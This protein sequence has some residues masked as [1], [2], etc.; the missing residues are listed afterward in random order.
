MLR[1]VSIMAEQDDLRAFLE[2]EIKRVVDEAKTKTTDEALLAGMVVGT[3]IKSGMA[4]AK[5]CGASREAIEHASEVF[6]T[7]IYGP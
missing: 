7:E 6:I 2:V 5:T 3:L 1:E 4:L